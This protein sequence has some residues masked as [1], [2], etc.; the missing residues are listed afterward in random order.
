[1]QLTESHPT[2]SPM[3]ALGGHRNR[4]CLGEGAAQARQLWWTQLVE[5]PWQ[6]LSHLWRDRVEIDGDKHF[7]VVLKAVQAGI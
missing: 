7:W 6:S 5:V 4:A 2:P 3:P 1:M